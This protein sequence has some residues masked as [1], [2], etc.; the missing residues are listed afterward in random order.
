VSKPVVFISYSH[1]DEK[2]KNR[3][4]THL[5]IA[6]QQ[7]LIELWDDRLIKGGEDWFQAIM[8]AIDNGSI[9]ILLISANSLTSEFIKNVEIPHLIKRRDAKFMRLYPIII[10]PCDWEAVTWLKE[11]NLR[12]R[13]GRPVGLTADQRRTATQ[14]GLDLTEVA[15]EIRVLLKDIQDGNL[16]SNQPAEICPYRG[17]EVFREEDKENF[18]GR[19]VFVKQLYTKINQDRLP[20]IAVVGSSG[21]GKSSVV[22]AGLLPLLRKVSKPVWDAA[23]FIPSESLFFDLAIALELA[24]NPKPDPRSMQRAI[25]LG[26]ELLKHEVSIADAIKRTLKRPG[27]PRRLLLV[28]DQFEEL[29][30][31]T[32]EPDRKPFIEALLRATRAVPV[33][34][35]LTL[36]A[37]FYSQAI[38]LTR[39]LSEIIQQGIVNLGPLIRDELKSVIENPANRLGLQF[40][41]GL[42]S[43]ILRAVDLQPDSLPL[44]EFALRELWENKEGCFLT[45][46]KY[47]EIG[48]VEGAI[49]RRADNVLSS[50]SLDQQNIALHALLKLVRVSIE[51]NEGADTR[52]R[53]RLSDIDDTSRQVLQVFVDGRL[54]VT[55]RN[56]ITGEETIEVVHEALIRRWGKLREALD[57]DREFL[58]WLRRLRFRIR[59]WEAADRDDGALLQGALLA[60]AKKYLF[61][62]GDEL[63]KDELEFIT[64][65]ERDE[66]QIQQIIAKSYKFF[67]YLDDGQKDAWVTT[68]VSCSQIDYALHCAFMITDVNL[69][70][71]ILADM[72]DG[73]TGVGLYEEALAA[74]REIKDGHAR[75]QSLLEVSIVLSKSGSYEAS[76][77]VA[78]EIEDE[79]AR[80]QALMNIS[81]ALSKAGFRE[82]ALA[83]ASEIKGASQRSVALIG[84][85][86]A[87]AEDGVLE[88]ALATVQE[89]KDPHSR[90]RRLAEIARALAASGFREQAEL[91]AEESLAATPEIENESSRGELLNEISIYFSKAG[92]YEYAL[93]AALEI[94]DQY[95]RAQALKEASVAMARA[96]LYDQALSTAA[97]IRNAGYHAQALAGVSK[98][99]AEAGLHEQALSATLDIKEERSR[100][101]ALMDIFGIISGAGY[102]EGAE[103]VSEQFFNTAGEAENKYSQVQSFARISEALS[104]AGFHEQT[105]RAIEQ[106]LAAALEIEDRYSR[107]RALTEV[108]VVMSRVGRREQAERAA[109]QA[110]TAALEI[111]EV[112]RRAETLTGIADS[113]IGV[114]AKDQAERAAEQALVAFLQIK[115]KNSRSP[116]LAK[117]SKVLD[118]VGLSE[119]SRRAAELLGDSGREQTMG[120]TAVTHVTT[121]EEYYRMRTIMG[122][123]FHLVTGGILQ[124]SERAA[125][126]ALSAALETQDKYV[127][128]AKL[129]DLSVIFSEVGLHERALAAAQEIGDVHPRSRRLAGVACA[130]AEA[131]FRE[132]SRRPAEQ[133]LSA[134]LE[135][136]DHAPRAQALIEASIALAGAGLHDQALAAV[137][138]IKDVGYRAQALA[139]V[140]GALAGAGLHDQALAAAREIEDEHSRNN[141]L[142]KMFGNLVQAER[143]ELAL[144]AA[145]EVKDASFRSQAFTEASVAMVKAGLR[146]KAERA[147]EQSFAATLEIEEMT[148]RT[149]ALAGIAGV[150]ISA[151]FHEQCQQVAIEYRT[152]IDNINY[153]GE[154]SKEYVTLSELLAKANQYYMA[155]ESADQ[156]SS[157]SDRLQ[158]YTAILQEYSMKIN[159][160]N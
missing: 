44:L 69:H 80:E 102:R 146:E 91:V 98:A 2:W 144:V 61:D 116:L 85:A 137:A 5:G 154:R 152:A 123:S 83:A 94:E 97:E 99:L 127:R 101:Q 159:P 86:G 13:D 9:A 124:Q 112:A 130:L 95:P 51:E 118:R 110:M 59:E 107:A 131:G 71:Q 96:G 113:L 93:S 149:K 132:Q 148:Q 122:R 78:L 139:G 11:M 35:L 68:I 72:S 150:L 38:G 52:R 73:L 7:G 60:E 6:Q 47:E 75:G 39:E 77:A 126:Q 89:I 3:L 23:I 56:E 1:K 134:A 119:Q 108:S 158:A 104:N 34:V 160:D 125:E 64:W 147:V 45:H 57:R 121:L 136:E 58:L 157:Y 141:V 16:P 25:K 142:T 129:T 48:G 117:I 32:P 37:D 15:K 17:L 115:D 153:S 103:R 30:T 40:E 46:T 67:R 55:N 10:E 156:C 41:S 82:Q 43:R 36:R 133:S 76:L 109:E 90:S 12:P 4:V 79:H 111:D 120:A 100:M 14:I 42:V 138:E 62:R 29:F 54:L 87:L 70:D 143:Y 24:K 145:A 18:F 66:Y 21:S 28:V 105:E 155:H 65:A 92:L 49:N 53:V 8:N 33:T 114:G 106:A 63:T 26:T 27:G 20:L 81:G 84:L 22:Q 88:Q 135:I 140:S 74:A 151:G 50:L 128:D 19:D 31:Q